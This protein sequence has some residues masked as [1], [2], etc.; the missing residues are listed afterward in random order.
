MKIHIGIGMFWPHSILKQQN[1]VIILFNAFLEIQP[2]EGLTLTDS[3][4][5]NFLNLYLCSESAN[6]FSVSSS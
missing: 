6:K 2:V 5:N 4:I 1:C 3:Q